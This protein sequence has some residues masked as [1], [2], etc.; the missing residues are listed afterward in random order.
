MTGFYKS[1]VAQGIWF[2]AATLFNL[3]SMH[4]VAGGATGWAGDMP[5]TAQ[6]VATLM[7]GVVVIGS[8]GWLRMYRIT[9]PAVLVLLVAG[10]VIR[11]LLADPTGYASSTT[12]ALALGINLFGSCAFLGGTFYAWRDRRLG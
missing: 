9:A 4:A 10:G 3:L 12:W 11:H 5:L 1:L 2:G 6:I 7:G 8:V